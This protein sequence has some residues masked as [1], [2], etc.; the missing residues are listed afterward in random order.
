MHFYET[1]MEDM[2][3]SSQPREES[4][5]PLSFLH[6]LK[7]LI[8][9]FNFLISTWNVYWMKYPDKSHNAPFEGNLENSSLDIPINAYKKLLTVNNSMIPTNFPPHEL[10]TYITLFPIIYAILPSSNEM[11]IGIIPML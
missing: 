2:M 3:K 9:D 1:L 11:I 10:S 7:H 4:P 5:H 6:C 8:D